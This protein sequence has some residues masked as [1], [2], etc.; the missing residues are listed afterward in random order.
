MNEIVPC[1]D[2]H[3]P[4]DTFRSS[5]FLRVSEY[6]Y[7]MAAECFRL[8]RHFLMYLVN[9]L[10]PDLCLLSQRR[11]SRGLGFF[12]AREIWVLMG[13]REKIGNAVLNCT[14]AR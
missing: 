11:K 8:N 10:Q 6:N 13:A 3:G 5:M 9:D 1:Y 2:T 7:T 4:P 14:I 12:A